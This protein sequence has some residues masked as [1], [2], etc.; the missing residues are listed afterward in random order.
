MGLG[1]EAVQEGC[2]WERVEDFVVAAIAEQAGGAVSVPHGRG[3]L[4]LR[5]RLR[6][7]GEEAGMKYVRL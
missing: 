7:S 2:G 6:V 1:D 5:P 3:V 4:S